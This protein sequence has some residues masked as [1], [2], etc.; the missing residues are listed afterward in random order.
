MTYDQWN[1]PTHLKVPGALDFS[2]GQYYTGTN[3][4]LN[5]TPLRPPEIAMQLRAV[6]VEALVDRF[7]EENRFAK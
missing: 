3:L 5:L 2:Y 4:P 6:Q 1:R 7:F